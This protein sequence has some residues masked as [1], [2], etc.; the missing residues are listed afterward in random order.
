MTEDEIGFFLRRKMTLFTLTDD[1]IY[2]EKRHCLRRLMTLFTST[3][4]IVYVD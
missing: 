1:I 4:D 2:V 3:D